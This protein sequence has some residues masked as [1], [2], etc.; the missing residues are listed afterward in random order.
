MVAPEYS[1]TQVIPGV[2]LLKFDDHI[3]LCA[4][5]LRFQEFYESENPEFFRRNFQLIDYI[6]R[7]ARR[8]GKRGAFTYFGDWNGFNVPVDVITELVTQIPDFND[9]D[10]FMAGVA[11]WCATHTTASNRKAYLIGAS[12]E[13]KE[14]TL[15][16]EYAHGFWYVNDDYRAEQLANLAALKDIDPLVFLEL[17]RALKR[18]GY[19]DDVIPDEMQAF[20]STGLRTGMNVDDQLRM[21]FIRTYMRFKTDVD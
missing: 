18:I 9:H 17:Q 16:H 7:Y 10:L 19:N 12:N 15:D 14:D 13:S 20:V 3:E 5:F 1:L 4:H 6:K 2:F 8:K 21:P 11:R